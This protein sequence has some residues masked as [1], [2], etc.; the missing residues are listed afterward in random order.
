[1]ETKLI[2]IEHSPFAVPISVAFD[3][4]ITVTGASNHELLELWVNGNTHTYEPEVHGA[5]AAAR[6]FRCN[7]RVADL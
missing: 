1:M 4:T 6:H 2:E 3:L 5:D 7:D